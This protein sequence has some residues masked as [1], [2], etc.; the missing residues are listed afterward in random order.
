MTKPA[1]TNR[2]QQADKTR[3]R[4][5]IPVF[6]HVKRF[7][8]KNYRVK[9]DVIKTEEYKLFGKMITLCLR[10]NRTR[11]E[12]NDQLRNRQTEKI[13]IVLTAD[14]ARM[15]PRLGKLM[16]INHHIDDLYKEHLLCWITALKEEGHAPYTACRMFITYYNLEEKD[17]DAAYK[18]YQR[19]IGINT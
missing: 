10:D 3:T 6:P 9:E 17:L 8:M 5:T 15:A 13:T 16:R 18:F 11:A 7:I 12:F 4:F 14:Q 19:H 2:L 1:N